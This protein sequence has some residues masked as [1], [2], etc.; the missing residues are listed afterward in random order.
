MKTRT[1]AALRSRKVEP[2]VPVDLS[3][4]LSAHSEPEPGSRPDLSVPV[5]DRWQVR[6]QPQDRW[7]VSPVQQDRWQVQRDLLAHPRLI[8][9][10]RQDLAVAEASRLEG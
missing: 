3:A 6:E 4:E 7:Q 5:Q 9:L 1:F 8:R 10:R 2:Q